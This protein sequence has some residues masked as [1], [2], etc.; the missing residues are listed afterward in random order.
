MNAGTGS[1]NSSTGSL[2]TAALKY[3]TFTLPG[4]R[5]RLDNFH[6]LAPFIELNDNLR[7]LI[8]RN[9]DFSSISYQLGSALSKC[10]NSRLDRFVL[11]ENTIDDEQAA[12]LVQSLKWRHHPLAL[13]FWDN[14]I[15][16]G[17][18][19]KVCY[20][21][22]DLLKD[23][24]SSIQELFMVDRLPHGGFNDFLAIIGSHALSEVFSRPKFRL[25][26]RNLAS[27]D[28]DG[29]DGLLTVDKAL[30]GPGLRIACDAPITIEEW[31]VYLECVQN[32][33]SKIELLELFDCKINDEVAAFIATALAETP[34]LKYLN[35]AE[36]Q[37][38]TRSGWEG[39]LNVLLNHQ[40]RCPLESIRIDYQDA[41]ELEPI[42]CHLLCDKSDIDS[43]FSSN[44]VLKEVCTKRW[45]EETSTVVTRTHLNTALR[46]PL[47]INENADKAVA[48]R[49]K[50]L[51][52]HFYLGA[53]TNIQ[54]FDRMPIAILPH[55]LEWIGR[56]EPRRGFN[57]NLLYK[58][59]KE[60]PTLFRKSSD[61]D[62]QNCAGVMN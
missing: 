19:N 3:S 57:F 54:V 15:L 20:A 58:I 4:G 31:R 55:A 16:N 6:I 41:A 43:I 47:N 13:V 10:K 30:T 52:F 53:P 33:D 36:A 42:L 59:V 5:H 27:M 45:S 21:V 18:S 22:A 12:M 34:S 40:S 9:V 37:S 61:G 7:C 24:G 39:F 23:K 49:E 17:E 14:I 1:M 48:A 8:I 2:G 60:F 62:S 11:R 32:P 56:G 35:M 26:T 44:H 29:V 46:F 50:I 28:R 51:V 25:S 38:M